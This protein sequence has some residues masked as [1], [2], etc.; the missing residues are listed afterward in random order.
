MAPLAE[1]RHGPPVGGA[2]DRNI[3]N[4]VTD[5]R[6]WVTENWATE[7]WVTENEAVIERT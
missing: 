6:I 2:D 3:D 4:W 5:G 7:S 1:L